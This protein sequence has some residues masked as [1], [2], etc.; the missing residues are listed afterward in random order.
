MM[1]LYEG[2]IMRLL[3][4]RRLALRGL[5]T[6]QIV[7]GGAGRAINGLPARLGFPVVA[8]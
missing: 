3:A 5:A 2:H 4:R 8:Q 1:R 6:A 7:Q